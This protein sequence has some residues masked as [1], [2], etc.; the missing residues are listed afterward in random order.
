MENRAPEAIIFD[1]DGTLST[2]RCGWESVM[3]E[4]MAEILG[5]WVTMEEIDRFID[6]ST[7]IQTIFQ[8]K[9]I[10]E[11]V[12]AHGKTAL[13]AWEY[14]EEYNRRLMQSVQKK[15]E[16]LIAGE[17]AREDYLMAGSE[18]LLKMLCERGVK[19]YVASG[20][21]QPDVQ[22]EAAALGM[23]KYFTQIAGAPL[24]EEKC[25]KEAVLRKLIAESGIP[26]EAILVVGDGKVEIALGH[27][28][29]TRTLGVASNERARCGMDAKKQ[30]R[31]EKAGADWIIGDYCNLKEIES[32]I[33]G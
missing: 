24:R 10:A 3:R 21:D 23:D 20:T 32:W 1:F 5:E 2:L 13:D 16:A 30:E 4:L 19:L 28:A 33:F 11:Q 18:A 25:S 9:W 12:A 27:Q 29:G 22:A 7:G 14:K 8:M 15:K 17:Y 31:L 26:A 6:E